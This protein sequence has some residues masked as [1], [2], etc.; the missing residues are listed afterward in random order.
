M[1][2]V[3]GQ[4][5]IVSL[6]EYGLK[7]NGTAHA[8]L[9][10]GPRHIGKGTLALDLA[11]ALNCEGPEAPCGQCSSCKR[12]VEGKHADVT[13]TGLDS[14]TEIGIDDIRGLQRLA[15]LPPYEGKCKAFIIDGAEYL[16]TE[17]AN[18]LLKILEEPPQR[19]V[20]LLLA[21][22]EDRLLPT[23]VSRCQRLELTP[24]PPDK[25]QEVLVSAYG[26]DPD[27]AKPLSHLCH[28]C[29]GWA[30]AA[31]SDDDILE[32]RSQD[33]TR[34]SSLPASDLSERFACAHELAT[35]FSHNRRAAAETMQVWLDWWRDLMLIKGG[36]SEAI[37]NTEHH[38]ALEEQARSL[39]LLDIKG[40]LSRLCLLQRDVSKNANPR[41]A[42]ECLMLGLPGRARVCAPRRAS[43]RAFEDSLEVL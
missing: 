2:R 8:Y 5:R 20:W 16:S 42:L 12:I 19:V 10:T 22:D 35:Q 32:Q 6:L 18:A 27:K 21:A 25:V 38:K 26:V 11:C 7:T 39:D 23:V 37:V 24:I 9:L 34:L 30:L 28:G 36:C 29:L 3:I 4:D 41:L 31:L 1:W 15:S 17:A 33:V 40:F 13:I 14:R 43:P